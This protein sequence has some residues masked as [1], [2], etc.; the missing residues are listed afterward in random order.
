MTKGSIEQMIIE[1]INPPTITKQVIMGIVMPMKGVK[2][3]PMKTVVTS[4]V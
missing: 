1:E 3:N 4:S 2:M